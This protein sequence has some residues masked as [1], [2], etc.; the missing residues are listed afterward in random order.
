MTEETA[1]PTL[2]EIRAERDPIVP[3]DMSNVLQELREL[4]KSKG[5]AMKAS[6]SDGEVWQQNMGGNPGYK[7]TLFSDP[8]GRIRA[9]MKNPVGQLVT[10]I[11]PAQLVDVVAVMNSRGI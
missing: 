4:F 6:S 8:G 9:E 1:D 11:N 2:S 3:V 10:E 7:W 5:F